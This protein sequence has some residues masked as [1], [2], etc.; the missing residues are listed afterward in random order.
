[1][2]NM[3]ERRDFIKK[4][5]LGATAVVFKD[6]PFSASSYA[7]GFETKASAHDKLNRLPGGLWSVMLTPFLDN[8]DVDTAGLKKLTEFYIQSGASGLFANCASSE[9][10]SLT[11]AERLLIIQTSLKAAQGKVPVVATG[12]FSHSIDKCAD[13]I[14]QVYDT[15]VAAVVL[16]TSQL[17]DKEED[18]DTL[19]KR[20]GQLLKL[21]GNIPLGIYEC[22]SPYKRLLSPELMKWLGE[23]GRFFYHKDTSCDPEAIK[24]KI[25]AVANTPFSFFNAD[26]PTALVSLKNGGAGLSPIAGNFYPE[27]YVELIK[28]A[29][30]PGSEKELSRLGARLTVMD[31]AAGL[32]YPM[33]A[34][35]FLQQR[36]LPITSVCRVSQREMRVSDQMRFAALMEMY[37]ETLEQLQS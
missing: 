37:K 17:A 23:T 13:F 32:F 14:K 4:S 25:K 31:S 1:M 3:K 30:K 36:G 11:D 28:R 24:L 6:L 21:T 15:G 29:N 10:Y 22:P 35:M 2:L 18:D 16:I 7:A 9:M 34:K 26:T 12:T 20:T 27:L 5:L 8:K 19:K 33:S